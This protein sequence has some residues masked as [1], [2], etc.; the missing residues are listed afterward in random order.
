MVGEQVP[1]DTVPVDDGCSSQNRA[2]PS[3]AFAG[4]TGLPGG[5]GGGGS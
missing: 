2:F 1:Q 3:R 5:A 4:V